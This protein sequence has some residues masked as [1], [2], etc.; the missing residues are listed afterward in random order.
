ML[1]LTYPHD[2]RLHALPAG[3]KMAALCGLTCVIFATTS[4][5]GLA[6]L[7]LGVAGLY[8]TGGRA[9]AALGL[10]LMRPLIPF[11]VVLAVWHAWLYLQ[12]PM[13]LTRFAQIALR[14]A[15]AVAAA[16]LV[17]LTTRLSDM[18]AVVEGLARP[19]GRVGLQPGVF[20][21]AVALV[22]RFVPVMGQRYGQLSD[23]WRARSARPPRAHL[24][25][26]LTLAAL[27][28]AEQVAQALRARGGAG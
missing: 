24:I 3:G 10:R 13:A 9:M 27:D 8:L 17:S 2:T 21:L 7:A 23:A 4:V 28:D 22:I 20:G 16:N 15:T 14:M 1:T 5:P 18:R 19:L 25:L 6:A 26:P 12:D 11:G